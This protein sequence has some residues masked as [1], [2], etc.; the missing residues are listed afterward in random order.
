MTITTEAWI[1]SISSAW[2]GKVGAFAAPTDLVCRDD[3]FDGFVAGV[4]KLRPY[5]RRD[6]LAW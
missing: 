2:R 1:M 5:A 6:S 3:F 4:S